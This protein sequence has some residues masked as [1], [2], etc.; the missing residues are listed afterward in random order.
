MPDFDR[1]QFDDIFQFHREKYYRNAKFETTLNYVQQGLPLLR[2]TATN[3]DLISYSEFMNELE[4]N[5]RS[6]R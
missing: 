1:K 4:T 3:L 5:R 2:Q 6:C